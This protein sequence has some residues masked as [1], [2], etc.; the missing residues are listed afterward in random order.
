M[1]SIP[2]LE[3]QRNRFK[4]HVPYFDARLR[5]PTP[6]AQFT[7]EPHYKLDQHCMPYDALGFLN[8]VAAGPRENPDEVRIFVVG[9][10]TMNVG[11]QWLDLIAGR[12]EDIFHHAG[13]GHVKAY[14]FGV[15]SSCTEQ[16]TSLIFAR[17]LD[18]DPDALVV[19]SGATDAFQPLTY[20]P[21]PGHPYNSFVT[22]SLY[23]YFF[24]A[25]NEA[26]WRDGL[27]YDQLIDRAFDYQTRLK[28]DVDFGSQA[29]E[30][31]IADQYKAS[32]RKLARI[33]RAAEIP[34]LYFLEPIVVRKDRPGQS[35]MNLAAPETLSLLARQYDRFEAHLHD[36]EQD[37]LPDN[38][39]LHDAS[40]LIGGDGPGTF[41]D[42]VHYDFDGRATVSKFIARHLEG[43]VARLSASR[44]ARLP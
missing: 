8:P 34:V 2:T 41:Y 18:L 30:I 6:Y 29:W 43:H 11:I 7:G 5:R 12:I 10:S 23:G 31:A 20:D 32:I 22:E 38:L 40:R 15:T 13:S 4:H 21:R 36:L 44:S 17:L 28:R 3:T 25:H 26:A 14:N 37:G 24:D 39:E 9:D 19:V 42:I 16:M 27:T 1:A 33:A 35:E